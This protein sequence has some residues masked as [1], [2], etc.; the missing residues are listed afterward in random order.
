MK[1]PGKQQLWLAASCLVCVVVALRNPNHLAGTEF[2]GGWLTGP[3][4][5]MTDIGTALL[6]L[7]LIVAFMYPRIAG[8]I[9]KAPSQTAEGFSE[10]LRVPCW[11]F[12]TPGS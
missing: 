8:A 12:W 5:S 7:A 1:K 9:E 4:L 3:L 2:S 6:L 11:T 10:S